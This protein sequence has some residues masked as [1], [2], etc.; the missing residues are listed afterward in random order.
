LEEKRKL[1]FVERE[2]EAYSWKHKLFFS[3]GFI[4]FCGFLC[5]AASDRD[6]EK[7]WEEKL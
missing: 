5:V 1:I 2:K 7:R 6:V 3:R 4:Q